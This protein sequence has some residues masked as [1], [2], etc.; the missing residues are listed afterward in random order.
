MLRQVY[1]CTIWR[2]VGTKLWHKNMPCL[3]YCGHKKH[4][5]VIDK[6]VYIFGTSLLLSGGTSPSTDISSYYTLVLLV[7]LYYYIHRHKYISIC[8]G[9]CGDKRY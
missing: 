4:I 5:V 9:Q 3:A 7:L 1:N 2:N 8:I 6:N